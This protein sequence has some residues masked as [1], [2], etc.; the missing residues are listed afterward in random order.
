MTI[1][2]SLNDPVLTG[3]TESE[4]KL[5]AQKHGKN[6][7]EFEK[8][9]RI[10]PIIKS[11]LGEP[12]IILLLV[13]SLIYF[14]SGNYNDAIFLAFSILL[15]AAISLYQDSRSTAAINQLKVFS[16]PNS[17][18]IRDG[19]TIEVL[20][21][22][23]VIGDLIIVEEG[24]TIPADGL[25]VQANDF[26][27][28]E[29][30]LSGESF[31]VSKNIKAPYNEIFKGTNVLT[32]LAISK[33]IA[34]GNQSQV[35]KIG[36]AVEEVKVEKTLLEKQ[37]SSFVGKMVVLGIVVFISVWLV[38]FINTNNLLESLLLSLTLAMSIL[39]EEIPVAFATFMA[40]GSWRLMKKGIIVKNTKTVESLGK[41]TTICLDKTGTIT[42]N[43]MVLT[44]IY[45]LANAFHALDR[46]SP[47]VDNEDQLKLIEYAMWASEPIPFDPMEISIHK[48]YTENIKTDQR[49]A[50]KIV[51]EYP[52]EG[53]PPM[54]THIFEN[55]L[56]KRIIAAKGAAEAII[57]VSNLNIA[58]KTKLAEAIQK[59]GSEGYRVLGVAYKDTFEGNFPIKQQNFEFEFLG[60]LAFY[61]PPKQNISS[62]FKKIY[63]AGIDIKIITGDNAETTRAIAS[64]A[65]LKAYEKTISGEQLMKYDEINLKDVVKRKTVFTRMFPEAKLKIINALK[66]NNEVVAMTGDGVNDGPAIKAANIGISM[67][68][69]GSELAKKSASLILVEDDLSKLVEAIAMGRKIYSNL[70]KAIQYIIS[71]HIPIILIVF[72]PLMLGWKF[73]NIFLPAHVILLELI[74]GPTCSIVYE[75]EPLEENA[76]L[77]GP[78][79]MTN[80]FFSWKELST[81]TIQ[82]LVITLGLLFIYQ[83]SVYSDYSES[84]TRT[85][86]FTTLIV[87]NTFLT[88]VNRSFYY[89][90][91]QTIKYKNNLI[92]WAIGISAFITILLLYFPPITIFFKLEGLSLEQLGICLLTGLV[93]VTWFEIVKWLKRRRLKTEQ[94]S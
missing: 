92:P 93:F 77:V 33:V 51:H 52:L 48:V 56:G 11:I 37:I 45:T 75:N 59:M 67:G 40:I 60:L 47:M 16:Q 82:G 38:N 46:N 64:K 86:V 17:K 61:D 18:V 53:K 81:S 42:E 43:K 25:L 88:L 35:G 62:V 26:T 58:Q 90:I 15:V 3:L 23:I 39:P 65:K 10:L 19:K 71:I 41:A 73:P 70:K 68:K 55:A 87:S 24:F 83:F 22:E 84:L 2:N 30:I 89:S 76:M 27:V 66:S 57:K 13:T 50:F 1:S 21:E 12:M 74:M 14:I 6:I 94:N 49:P 63:Q 78:R 79:K 28:D 34:I 32:G 9:N 29:S 36:K 54:M 20:S 5:S 44:E 31:P 91:F 72:T 69:R 7:V 8:E 80:S 85:M 4:V